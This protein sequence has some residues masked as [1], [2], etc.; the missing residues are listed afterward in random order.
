MGINFFFPITV[1]N[2]NSTF[3]IGNLSIET[4]L[5]YNQKVDLPP[6]ESIWLLNLTEYISYPQQCTMHLGIK[7]FRNG[8]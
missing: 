7:L 1:D 4:M 6:T 5:Y 2:C 3:L 8:R